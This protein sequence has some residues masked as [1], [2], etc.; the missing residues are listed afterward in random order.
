VLS[1]APLLIIVIAIAGF[2]FGREAA[3]GQIFYQI[4]DMVGPEGA[5]TI[6]EMIQGASNKGSGVLASLIGLVTLLF[7]ATSGHRGAEI[8]HECHLGC[9]SESRCRY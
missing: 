1:I 9:T 6:E 5:R 3:Q 2:V 4:R 7:G 8:Q